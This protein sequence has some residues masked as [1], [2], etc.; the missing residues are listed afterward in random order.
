MSVGNSRANIICG[1]QIGNDPL[2]LP[3]FQF[4]P[5]NGRAVLCPKRAQQPELRIGAFGAQD[6]G[7]MSVFPHALVA[8]EP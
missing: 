4:V 3:V 8:Y 7:G 6:A 1:A 5:G 2:A